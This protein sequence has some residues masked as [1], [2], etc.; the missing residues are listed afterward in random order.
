MSNLVSRALTAV[1]A[2]PL[3][4]A[5]ILWQQR[6]GFGVLVFLFSAL[7]MGE[8]TAMLLPRIARAQRVAIMAAGTGL[9]IALYFRPDLAL[10][11]FLAALITGAVAVLLSPGEISG[12]AARAGIVVLGLVY[13]GVLMA[14][15]ALVHRQLPDG[16]RW[17]LAALGATF[18]NDTGAY[19][20]GRA[21][22]R[23][24]L[25]P[26]ISPGKTVE[27]AVG[28]LFFSV[29]ALFLF[30]ATFFPALTAADCLFIGVPGS[31]L[32]PAGDLFESMLKRSAGVKDS[33]HL[34]PGHG[35]VLDRLDAVL[36]VGAWIFV[37]AS[38]L[39]G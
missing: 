9:T 3:L 36:F 30:R 27:G 11:W 7:A 26:A 23:H 38:F 32:G 4:A 10:V 6:L 33:S 19:F 39:R 24:K 28:G 29:G 34:I 25:Y 5:L 14:L 20:S 1:L 21:L 17:V 12:A 8:Y 15:L 37:Y 2:L 18:A 35:G 16:P 13:V 31:V 22:G